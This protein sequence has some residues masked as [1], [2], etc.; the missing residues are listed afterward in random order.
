MRVEQSFVVATLAITV[1]IAYY[2][3]TGESVELTYFGKFKHY[4]LS[5]CLN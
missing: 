3:G 2:Y 4:S 1:V 5:G